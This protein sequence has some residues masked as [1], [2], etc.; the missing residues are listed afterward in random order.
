MSE[1]D[2]PLSYNGMMSRIASGWSPDE[3]ITRQK[4][5]P[6]WQ[7]MLEQRHN[8]RLEEILIVA[9]N[10]GVTQKT[11]ATEF[12]VDLTTIQRCARRYGIRWRK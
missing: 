1:K 2:N 8:R 6:R 5:Q 9:R 7:W 12:G 11:L 3:V 10:E 4:R